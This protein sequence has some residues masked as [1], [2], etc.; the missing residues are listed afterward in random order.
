MKSEIL[1]TINQCDKPIKRADLLFHLRGM[2]Y[3]CSDREMRLEIEQLIKDGQC[4]ASGESGY[5]LIKTREHLEKAKAYLRSKSE[6]I[7]IRANY[8]EKNFREI[9]EEQYQPTLF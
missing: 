2:G 8:L 1:K 3:N 9:K 7:A 5:Q 6:A 4:I